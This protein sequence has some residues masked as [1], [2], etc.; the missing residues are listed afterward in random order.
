MDYNIA[1]DDIKNW[2]KNLVIIQYRQSPKNRAFLDAITEIIFA[3]CLPLQIRDLCLNV[4][5][6][7]GHQLDVVG[8]WVGLDRFYD[9]INL[10]EHKYTALVNYT[11]IQTETYQTYQGGFSTFE[12]FENNDGG[13]LMY[14][15]YRNTR[16]KKNQMGDDIFRTLIK[17]KIIKNSIDFTN[18]NIDDAIYEWSNGEVYTTWDTMKVTYHYPSTWSSIFTLAIYKGILLAPT[19]CIIETVE[20]NG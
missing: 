12:N 19:G 10:W 20:I 15:T 7:I 13:F 14:K 5:Q 9:G 3:K 17:L 8:A 18:K 4:E 1:L 16:V 2:I 6:S 11:N